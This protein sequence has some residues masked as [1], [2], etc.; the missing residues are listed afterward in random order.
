MDKEYPTSGGSKSTSSIP[1]GGATSG[2]NDH[3]L[4][5]GKGG[6]KGAGEGAGT[7]YPDIKK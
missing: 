3:C 5:D 7:S 6:R 2:F 1:G 4:G